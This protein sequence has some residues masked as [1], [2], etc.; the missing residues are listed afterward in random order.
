MFGAGTESRGR[1]RRMESPPV[2]ALDVLPSLEVTLL[3]LIL[4]F[5]YAFVSKNS[6]KA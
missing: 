1:P 2:Q 6:E 4:S 5:I 3:L